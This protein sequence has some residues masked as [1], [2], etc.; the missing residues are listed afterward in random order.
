MSA[1]VAERDARDDP[2]P[3]PPPADGAEVDARDP[4]LA[5][6]AA[7]SSASFLSAASVRLP[8]SEVDGVVPSLE[9]DGG[10]T[11]EDEDPAREDGAALTQRQLVA[12]GRRLLMAYQRQKKVS[13]GT[14]DSPLVLHSD[15]TRFTME[16]DAVNADNETW[17]REG[18][19]LSIDTTSTYSNFSIAPSTVATASM[20]PPTSLSG[21][22]SWADFMQLLHQNARTHEAINQQLAALWGLMVAE[23]VAQPSIARL[24]DSVAK[25]MQQKSDA[26]AAVTKF[27][28]VLGSRVFL[29]GKLQDDAVQF[30]S[31][32]L[33]LELQR[34]QALVAELKTELI[35]YKKTQEAAAPMARGRSATVACSQP[36]NGLIDQVRVLGEE[37]EMRKHAL[38]TLQLAKDDAERRCADAEK[39]LQRSKQAVER[40][41]EELDQQE[42]AA[43]DKRTLLQ[44][45]LAV[46]SRQ[47]EQLCANIELPHA[48]ERWT[49]DEGITFFR[50]NDRAC[51]PELEDPRVEV[52]AL[53]LGAVDSNGSIAALKRASPLPSPQYGSDRRRELMAADSALRRSF[54]SP[55]M[56]SGIDIDDLIASENC[57]VPPDDGRKHNINDFSTPLPAGWEMR[58]TTAGAVYFL[59]KYTNTTTWAD[60]R[61]DQDDPAVPAS[62]SRRHSS[63]LDTRSSLS[64]TGSM[65]LSDSQPET[66]YVDFD[67]VF[68]ERGP[69][70]IHFQANVPDEGATVRRLLPDMAAEACGLVEPFDRLVAVNKH[71]VE[72]APFRH[73]MLLL[74][75]GLRP[76]TLTFR[77]DSASRSTISSDRAGSDGRSSTVAEGTMVEDDG[78][79][80]LDEE[81]VVDEAPAHSAAQPL[82]VPTTRDIASVTHRPAHPGGH[83]SG[84]SAAGSRHGHE[85]DHDAPPTQEEDLTVA[86]RIITGVFSL[87]WTAPPNAPNE[88]HTV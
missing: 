11:E 17:R 66:G 25:L 45:A 38:Q 30:L 70:G 31:N 59:N 83:V 69:I 77:R 26:E 39:L 71:S 43:S 87:F 51:A 19:G 63:A 40:L 62:S 79:M 23:Q 35:T 27:A 28:E 84:E 33:K 53:R 86:D 14:K 48:V 81:V 85:R 46:K 15:W 58:V 37:L 56:N 42:K 74:Q 34:S 20:V 12:R 52:A 78:L 72:G 50:R 32:Q 73:V 22:K 75:G 10:E 55:H 49:D 68:Q 29:T 76:L 2:P 60:P 36:S 5:Q 41:E 3:P 6:R 82:R 16:E 44:R 18:G 24:N 7:T 9:E 64:A 47:L 8:L 1:S 80:H 54:S 21:D 88:L 13:K 57:H 65:N 67:V 4:Q 61:T